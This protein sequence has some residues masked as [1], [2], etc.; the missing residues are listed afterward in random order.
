MT[1]Q[2]AND[3][4]LLKVLREIL[5]A[6]APCAPRHVADLPVK[7]MGKVEAGEMAAR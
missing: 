7:R 1:D 5:S 2:Q 4:Q 3:M 6:P